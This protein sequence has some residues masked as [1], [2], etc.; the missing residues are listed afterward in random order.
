M[1]LANYFN[2]RNIKL[3]P[4]E[5]DGHYLVGIGHKQVSDVAKLVAHHLG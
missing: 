3:T 1:N 5:E 2:T 4:E